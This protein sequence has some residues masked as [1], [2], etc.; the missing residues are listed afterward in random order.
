MDVGEIG[1]G[2][3]RAERVVDQWIGADRVF[4]IVPGK[5][6]VFRPD[7]PS[8]AVVPEESVCLAADNGVG[9]PNENRQRLFEPYMTTRAKGTGLGLAIVKKI[10]E[11]HSGT[12]SMSNRKDGGASVSLAFPMLPAA[13]KAAAE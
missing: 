3:R 11:E 1:S 8:V 7:R 13:N 12:I 2:D 10:M 5:R 6:Q 4:R 9:L